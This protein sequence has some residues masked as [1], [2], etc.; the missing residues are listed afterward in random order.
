MHPG[1]MLIDIMV[2]G[3]EAC[4]SCVHCAGIKIHFAKM[5]NF[6][7]QH[8]FQINMVDLNLRN[9]SHPQQSRRHDNFHDY[10]SS[11]IIVA[12][13]EWSGIAAMIP[14]TLTAAVLIALLI[15]PVFWPSRVHNS[16]F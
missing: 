5:R 11:A 13:A 7:W 6:L 14:P 1:P 10:Y 15:V 16:F 4:I 3:G 8:I 2:A 12:Y 9:T